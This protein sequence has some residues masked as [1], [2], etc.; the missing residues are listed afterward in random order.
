MRLY[1]LIK[2][3]RQALAVLLI[4]QFTFALPAGAQSLPYRLVDTDQYDIFRED[5]QAKEEEKLALEDPPDDA[6]LLKYS[7]EFWRQAVTSVEGAYKLD[8]EPEPIP[9]LTLLN[10]TLSLPLYGTSIALT[11]RYVLGFKMAAKKYKKDDNNSVDERSDSSFEMDQQLQLKMQGKILERVFV[12]IDYDDQREEEKSISVAYRGKPGELVQLAEFGDINL[13]LPQTEFIAYEKQLFGAKMH[14]QHQNANLY[15]IGSQTKGSSKQKQFVGSSVAEIV[16]LADKDYIRRTYYDLTFG[17][18]VPDGARDTTLDDA[19]SQWRAYIG[20][21]SPGSEEI[22]LDNND[23]SS[24][25]VPVTLNAEDF[26]GGSTYS[27]KWELLTRGTDYTVDYASGIITFKRTIKAESV[28]AVDYRGT[29]GNQLSSWGTSNTIKLIKTENDQ[30]TLSGTDQTATKMEL[31]TYYNIGAQKITSDNG[32]GNFILQLQ[33]AN[34][35]AVTDPKYLYPTSIIMDFDTGIFHLQNRLNDPGLYGTTPTSSKNMTFKIQY[36][37]TVKTYFIEADI[38][39]Q[40]ETVKLNGRTLTRNNDYYIDYTSGFITFYKGDEITENST[41]DITYDTTNGS[42]SNNSVMGGRLD[43]KLFDKIVMGATVLK[44]GGDKP[45]TV[46]QVGDYAKDLLVYGADINGKD[47]KL[48]EPLSV[49]FSA[50]VAKSSKKQNLFGYAMIDSMNETNEQVAGSRVF[51]DW[52]IASNP[53]GKT[54]FWDSIH[55]DTQDLPSLEINPH[56]IADYND[57]QQVLVIDYDFTKGVNFDGRD[58]VSIVYPLSTSGLDLSTKTSFELTMLGET[59][60]PQVN[61]AFGNISEY[62]DNSTGM[63]TQCGVGVPKT[64]DV[65]CR[66]SLAPNEDIGWLFTDP[67]G[68]EHRYNPFVNNVYNPESQPNGRIDTQD[69]NGNGKY[70]TES[71]P[72]QGNFGFAGASIPGLVGNVADN[73][74][75]QTFTAPLTINDKSEWTAVRHLRITLKKGTKLKGQI[76]IANVALSGTAWN[77]QEGISPSVF[78]AAGINNV[79][80][81]N[82]EPIFADRTGDGREVFKYLYGSLDNYKKSTGSANAL[83][84][85]LNLKFNTAS[86]G[87]NDEVYANRNFSTMDFSQH[88]EV[89]FL[90]HGA[91]QQGTDIPLNQDGTE[92]FLKVGTETNY[93]KVVVPTNFRGWRLISLKMVDSNGDGIADTFENLSDPSY[94]VRVE[95]VRTSNGILNFQEVSLILA[96]VQKQSGTSGSQGEVWLNVI[97]LAGAITKDGTAYKGDV[98][99]KL[100]EWGSAGAKYKY[101]DSNFETPLSVAKNQEVTQQ[102]Y[103]VKVNKIKEFP[104]EANL[105]KSS[106]VTPLITDSKDYNTVSLLDKGKVDRQS[107]M[108]RGDFIKENLPKIGLEYTTDQVKYDVMKRKDDART[109]GATLSHTAGSFKNI[110]AGYHITDSSIDY[111]RS[112]HLESANYYNTDENTQKMNMKVTYQPNNSFT[113]TPSYSLSKSKEDRTQYSSASQQDISYPKA[114]TQNTGFNSTWKINKWLAPSVS[115]NISTQENN[116]LNAKTLTASGTRVEVGVG[117]VK[118][119]NRNADGGVSLTLNGNELLP[120]SKLFNTFVISSSYRIQ[121]ADAWADV[122]S[123]FDSRKALW[124]RGGSL[125]DVGDYGYRKSLI[126]RDTFTS[127]QRWSPLARYEMGGAASPLK[128]ISLI[129]NFT[130]TLQSNEQTGTSYDSTSLT[131]PDMTFSISDLEKF[132]YGGRW[133]SSSNLK[134]RYS[135]VEQTNTGTDEQYTKQYGGDL[136]FMLFN[137]FDTVLNYTRKDSD[138]TDLRAGTSLETVRDSDI[139]A[140]TSFYVGSLRVTPKVLYSSH[141]KWLVAGKISESTTTTTPSLNLRWDFNIPRGIKLPFVNK[142]YNAT[143]RVIW[144]TTLTYT[145]KKSPVEVKDNYQMYD[146]TTSLDYEMS[147]NLRFTLSGGLTVLNHSY[148]ETEDY[149]AYNVAANVTIQF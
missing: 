53:S 29:T 34:G 28:L 132:F 108:V 22:Y 103:F 33:D 80:N 128:T 43:Y 81:A 35:Q 61:F 83:D 138:K 78:S 7:N 95:P 36:E 89:R 97:H 46:P 60:G 73:T 65:Y 26:L 96:G 131:L 51:R 124:I 5:Q 99:V 77:P 113:F 93:D 32:K 2:L 133:F 10:P 40:S 107:T 11:G 71:I 68:T 125:K 39:V 144:N 122:D 24:D 62:S 115:Y 57:K 31:K 139:S 69:L 38:V 12:D 19:Y 98:V 90:L 21:I 54:S 149:T 91:M 88:R 27:A 141:D 8:K 126:L 137:Y 94:N 92:F 134:L 147:Q 4:L 84:Q 121:D 64:E 23:T 66:N 86:L 117:E 18:N 145:D 119:V 13:S 101:Q 75:W 67:D 118:T 25:Y 102:E 15:L 146:V 3:L 52:I 1:P 41:I 100:D 110:S 112:K 45:S 58:E 120:N 17:G 109:Y 74:T 123:G 6:N 56:S 49:D 142:M 79:D 114:L 63:D 140:Q 42:N 85:S 76:K 111:D 47:I 16:S 129:N 48:A 9:D 14:L 104:M 106:T 44:E 55:W 127:T 130:K 116:N 20:S 82:Y 136:R 72:S 37:S 148:V 135:W 143:N 30:T 50:E 87:D 59:G 70:D 105:T